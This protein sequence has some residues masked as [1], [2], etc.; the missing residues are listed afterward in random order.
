MGGRHLR[1]RRKR[2]KL[3]VIR[4]QQIGELT[5]AS[6]ATA[7]DAHDVRQQGGRIVAG[8]AHL[9]R[10]SARSGCRNDA[11]QVNETLVAVRIGRVSETKVMGATSAAMT[12][13]LLRRH[14][15]FDA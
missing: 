3:D 2:G 14:T 10:V 7:E 4:A 12:I 9:L 15:P 6:S 8:A 11:R 13:V 5:Q 1:L